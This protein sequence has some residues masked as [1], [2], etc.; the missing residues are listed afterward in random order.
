VAQP[1]YTIW[2]TVTFPRSRYAHRLAGKHASFVDHRGMPTCYRELSDS[3]FMRYSGTSLPSSCKAVTMAR[4]TFR[5]CPE[6]VRIPVPASTFL[7]VLS[8]NREY[9][10]QLACSVPA[11]LSIGSFRFDENLSRVLNAAG[12]KHSSAARTMAGS[13]NILP[14]S[15]APYQ[16]GHSTKLAKMG[17]PV[18]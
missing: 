10:H 4:F 3:Y 12:T 6:P 18:S 8:I 14:A 7:P 1:T 16:P 9:P 2:S 5:T 11:H 15:L 13:A 17:L